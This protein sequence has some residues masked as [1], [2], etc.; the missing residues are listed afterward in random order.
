MAKAK[1]KRE[2]KVMFCRYRLIF[3]TATKVGTGKKKK[4][5][6]VY[7]S[8]VDAKESKERTPERGL[9]PRMCKGLLGTKTTKPWEYYYQLLKFDPS[10]R[11]FKDYSKG[12]VDLENSIKAAQRT[13]LEL[14]MVLS[15]EGYELPMSAFQLT[16]LDRRPKNEA[17]AG[18]EKIDALKEYQVKLPLG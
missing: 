13:L 17:T 18:F 8:E 9:Y 3:R 7:S 11:V 14:K 1:V 6:M 2:D 4:T 16:I 15:S 10:I 12:E 5:E